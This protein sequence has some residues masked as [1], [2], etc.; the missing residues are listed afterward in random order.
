M[1][2]MTD[3]SQQKKV[4]S[5]MDSLTEYQKEVYR[6][7]RSIK[8]EDDEVNASRERTHTLQPLQQTQSHLLIPSSSTHPSF[9]PMHEVTWMQGL[10]QTISDI[11]LHFLT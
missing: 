7:L 8:S 5:R 6:R 3:Q 11:V 9:T 10:S 1:I 4:I 2:E